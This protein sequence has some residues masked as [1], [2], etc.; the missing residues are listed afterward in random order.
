[1]ERTREWEDCIYDVEKECDR[2]LADEPRGMGF[3]HSYWSTKRAVL[4]R[5]GIR[6]KSPSAMNPGVMFD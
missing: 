4:A 3:C 1:M 2:I 6:W 5:R